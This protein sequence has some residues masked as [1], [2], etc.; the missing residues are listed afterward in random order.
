MD[1]LSHGLAGSMLNRALTP[2]PRAQAAMLLGFAVAM[3]P[4]IDAL[5]AGDP[6]G[7]L[8]LHRGWTHSWVF[9]PAVSFGLALLAQRIWRNASLAE[10]WL[11]CAV[12][13]ASHILFDWITSYGTMF[14]IPFTRHR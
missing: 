9:L 3:L 2:R 13:Q 6:I 8:S 1:T 12:G 7:Y 10:L 14:L 11:W 4:D 5:W